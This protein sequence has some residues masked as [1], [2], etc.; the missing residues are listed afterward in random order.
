M[1]LWLRKAGGEFDVSFQGEGGPWHD[2]GF[3]VLSDT[4][5]QV[6]CA[7]GFT[8]RG[9]SKMYCDGVQQSIPADL[10]KELNCDHALAG[11]ERIMDTRQF[12]ALKCQCQVYAEL[13]LRGDPLAPP[14]GYEK[15]VVFVPPDE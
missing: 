13:K 10:W 1:A 2:N 9:A 5:P 7:F 4:A 6:F 15:Q 12:T 11:N 14:G 3:P 8:R